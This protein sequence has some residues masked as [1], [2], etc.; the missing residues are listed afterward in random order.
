MHGSGFGAGE[1]A[2]PNVVRLPT[3]GTV[4]NQYTVSKQ[5]YEC[6]SFVFQKH[7]TLV[8][9]SST[10]ITTS[11]ASHWTVRRR[12]NDMLAICESI[13]GA[14]PAAQ[15]QDELAVLSETDRR[16]FLDTADLAF[17]WN[18]MRIMRIIIGRDRGASTVKL[19]FQICNVVNH[20]SV[21]NICQ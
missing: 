10:R 6:F 19:V 11:D 12:T 16:E 5:L 7:M 8:R 14:A 1:S 9:V 17:P 21:Q 15:L 2:T 20:N 3:E 13:S 18:K 4:S